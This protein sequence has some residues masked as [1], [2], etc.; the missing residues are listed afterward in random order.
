MVFSEY[1]YNS[2]LF[3]HGS[4]FNSYGNARDNSFLLKHIH[5]PNKNLAL[6]IVCSTIEGLYNLGH[7]FHLGHMW[8]L[9]YFQRI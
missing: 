6:T 1:K 2:I 5:L 3:L 9:I 4:V 8:Q 7:T